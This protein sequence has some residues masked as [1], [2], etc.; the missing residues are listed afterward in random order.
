MNW[1]LINERNP[2]KQGKYIV[3]YLSTNGKR[4]VEERWFYGGN[5][6]G[7]TKGRGR[8]IAWMP[9]PVPYSGPYDGQICR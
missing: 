2:E 6:Q 3:T 4:K 8:I 7:W 5:L 1:V 9:M